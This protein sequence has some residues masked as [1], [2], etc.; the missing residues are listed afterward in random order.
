MFIRKYGACFE[1]VACQVAFLKT[2]CLLQTRD[3]HTTSR[4]FVSFSHTFT[5]FDDFPSNTAQVAHSS[6]V[7]FVALHFL[8]FPC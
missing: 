8:V 1:G 4:F 5:F 6:L 3:Q 2:S 7:S